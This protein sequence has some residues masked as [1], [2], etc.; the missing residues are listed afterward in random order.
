MPISLTERPCPRQLSL[1][2]LLLRLS[3]LALILGCAWAQAIIVRHDKADARYVVDETDFPQ[4]FSLHYRFDNRVCM[5]T[6]IAPNWALTAGHC[7]DQTPLGEQLDKGEAWPLKIGGERYRAVEL[8][9]HPGYRRDNPAQSV[10][11]ALLRLDRPVAAVAP[12]PLYRR[13]DEAGKVAVFLGWGFTGH[14]QVGRRGNDGHFR[15]AHNQVLEA[16]RWLTFRFDDPREP[17]SQALPLEGVPGLGDSGGPA[18]LETDQGYA[19]L[20]VALGELA[21]PENPDAPQGLYGAVEIYERT[22]SHL[23]WIESAI[24]RTPAAAMTYS[25]K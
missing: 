11:L 3:A 19:L 16:G 1:R 5:A 4:V 8:I 6:L 22:S 10:D 15:R 12:V 21:D 2:R 9:L 24:G 18:L 13:R 14:G 17:D 25:Q 23:Q 7:S 20:G